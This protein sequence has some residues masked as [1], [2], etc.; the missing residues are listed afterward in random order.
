MSAPSQQTTPPINDGLV[1]ETALGWLRPVCSAN[2][3]ISLAWQERPFARIDEPVQNPDVSRET[4]SQLADYLAGR[5]QSFDLPLDFSQLSP[6]RRQWLACLAKIPY[7]K[8]VSYQQLA[9]SWGNPKAARAAGQACRLN[10]LPIIIPCH[11]VVSATNGLVQ[12]SGGSDRG[13]RDPA[14]LNRK[15]WLQQLEAGK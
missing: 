13:P 7:G 15:I 12:Y 9:A 10:P 5:R 8:L 1:L 11:R 2:G 4:I 14:N 6:A 3:L